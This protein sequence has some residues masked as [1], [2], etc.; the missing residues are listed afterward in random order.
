[1]GKVEMDQDMLSLKNWN[2]EILA[3]AFQ[4]HPEFCLIAVRKNQLLGFIIAGLL[5]YDDKKSGRIY[6]LVINNK[7]EHLN[8]RGD[9]LGALINE[10]K[11]SEVRILI[12]EIENNDMI[13]FFSHNGFYEINKNTIMGLDID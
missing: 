9:I 8:I 6:R 4:R 10:L 13:N 1:M 7:Y 2:E 3:D 12:T 5:T 11:R